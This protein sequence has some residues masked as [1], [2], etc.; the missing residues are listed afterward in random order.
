MTEHEVEEVDAV[1]EEKKVDKYNLG[2][3]DLD[4]VTTFDDGGDG[5]I[6]GMSSNLKNLEEAAPKQKIVTVK[7][8]ELKMIMDEL[9]L[10]KVRVEAALIKNDGNVKATIR[11]LMGL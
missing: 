10:P 4:K 9:E 3:A 2:A 7:P 11:S 5:D 8:E 6:R 1:E